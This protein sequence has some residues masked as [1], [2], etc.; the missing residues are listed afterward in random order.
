MLLPS[1]K[2][3]SILFMMLAINLTKNASLTF[4]NYAE[5]DKQCVTNE[6]PNDN[7]SKKIP[8]R[9]LQLAI[10]IHYLS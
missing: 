9:N 6:T 8:P 5:K 2:I 10:W 7:I 4:I 3:F 1:A